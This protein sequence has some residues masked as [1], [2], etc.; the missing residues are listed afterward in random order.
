[1]TKLTRR[2]LAEY[3][4]AQLV[5]G[6]QSVVEEL[7][8]Y[9][10]ESGRT[11]EV[12]LVVRDIESALARR[13]VLVA[14]VASAHPLSDTTRS[15]LESLLKQTFGAGQLHLEENIEPSLLG[16]VTVIAA[17]KELD[18]SARRRLQQLRS[19]KV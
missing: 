11:R 12:N 8:A 19:V 14:H 16:G 1:M 10:V 18:A 3:V 7:A 13:G 9:L 2:E 4:A 17:D 15:S 6:K 5:S